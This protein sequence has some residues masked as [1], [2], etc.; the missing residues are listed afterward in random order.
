MKSA[1]KRSSVARSDA[2]RNL[3]GRRLASDQLRDSALRALHVFRKFFL[4]NAVLFVREFFWYLR[5]KRYFR[6]RPHSGETNA[7][8]TDMIIPRAAA[9]SSLACGNRENAVSQYLAGLHGLKFINLP[10]LLPR[11]NWSGP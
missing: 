7:S 1:Y 8:P 2:S 6:N 11:A 4:R 9:R 5:G 3:H 10:G